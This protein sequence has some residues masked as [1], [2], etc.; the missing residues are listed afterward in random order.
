MQ[1]MHSFFSNMGTHKELI[2]LSGVAIPQITVVIGATLEDKMLKVE[3]QQG[4]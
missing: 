3:L 4:F 2:C 1:N